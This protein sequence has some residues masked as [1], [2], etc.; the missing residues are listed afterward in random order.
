[1]IEMAK[2]KTYLRFLGMTGCMMCLLA[3]SFEEDNMETGMSGNPVNVTLE[4][5]T[6]A[7]VTSELEAPES[8]IQTLRIYAFQENELVGYHYMGNSS[9]GASGTVSC[10]MRL[11]SGEVTFYTIANETAAGGLKQ[12]NGNDYTLLPGPETDNPQPVL[13]DIK[14]T[15]DE[16]KQITFSTL[17]E[18]V[19]TKDDDPNGVDENKKT[20]KGAVLPMATV[21][22]A[23]VSKNGKVSIT[24]KR[25]VAKL[26]LYF[27]KLGV[28]T[29]ILYLGRGL[30]LYNVPQYGYLFPGNKY[31]GEFDRL[32]DMSDQLPEDW[33]NNDYY[34]D[35]QLHQKNG[36][37]ILRSGWPEEP[38]N[39]GSATEENLQKTHINEIKKFNN[40]PEGDDNLEL[41]QHMPGRPVYLFANPNEITATDHLPSNPAEDTSRGYYLKIMAHMHRANEEGSAEHKGKVFYVSLPPVEA[42]DNIEVSSTIIVDGFIGIIPHWKITPWVT[43]GADIDFD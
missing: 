33:K 32:E 36:K 15:P 39:P 24:L 6:R 9:T 10:T 19:L 5:S 11:P 14:V 4:V 13:K 37:V 1:M 27:S 34:K 25:S 16:L 18:A 38:E 2:L 7:D 40:T 30:Y 41:F 22:E 3:C 23:T 26:N 35:S 31:T 20:Y 21:Q 28:N 29:D 17:P 43:G 42:N 8:E 12:G